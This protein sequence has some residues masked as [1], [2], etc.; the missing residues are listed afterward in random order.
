MIDQILN[1]LTLASLCIAALVYTVW[2]IHLIIKDS[3]IID[4]IWGAGFGIVAALLYWEVPVK[5]DYTQFLAVFP[6]LW[7]LRY[8]IF[9]FRRN[10]GNGEDDR[11][12]KMRENAKEAGYSWTF[13]SFMIYTF[14]ALSMLLVSVPLIIGLAA[15]ESVEIGL[16]SVIGGLIWVVGF[17]FE[18]IAD[19]Q[20]DAFKQKHKDYNG[21]YENKP[22]LTTGL[23]KY[24][25][26]PNYFGNACMWWGIALIASITPYG[27]IG[28]L[29]AAYMNY[30][31]V[32]LTGK[33]NN[34]SKM[35]GRKAYRDYIERTSGFVPMPPKS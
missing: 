20:L 17:L 16:V 29:G 10:F 35:I 34:E 26:H 1:N 21:D 9:I 23:W 28:F 24:S 25:R 22:L 11:Y 30:A 19:I 7:A 6:I 4:L 8:T 32:S 15:P 31:L 27:W 12:T 5:T 2:I 14:Q 13:Y 33:A 3:S 18:T